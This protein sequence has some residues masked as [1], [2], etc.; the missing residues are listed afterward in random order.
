MASL[1]WLNAVLAVLFLVIGAAG[2]RPAVAQIHWT[3]APEFA[4]P[5]AGAA[6]PGGDPEFGDLDADGDFDL[7]YAAV[8]QSYRNVGTPG[9]PS[10][11]EDSSLIEGVQYLQCMTVCLADLDADG[12][13]DLSA[14]L[15]NAE[16]FPLWY[17]ENVGTPEDPI[18]QMENSMYGDL[19][20]GSWTCPELADLDGDSDLDLLLASSCELRAYRNEGTPETP[21]WQRDDTFVNGILLPQPYVDPTLGD[22][23]GDGDPDL[24][25]GGRWGEGPIVCYENAGTPQAPMWAENES[26]LEGVD[27]D[28]E[29]NG[30]D[31]ADLDADGDPD[32]LSRQSPGGAVVYLNCGPITLVEEPSTWG[33]IKAVFR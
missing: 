21:S 6:G 18:W 20:P 24:V 4:P 15:L 11:Q 17:Y 8:L 9:A 2:P 12:D 33:K 3:V 16:A 23:D 27:R 32:L 22:L 30:V 14:G 13:L 1:R 29:G 25:L 31:L 26:M 5:G 28:V 19:L 7:I 10:W